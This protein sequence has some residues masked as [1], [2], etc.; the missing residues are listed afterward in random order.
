MLRTFVLLGLILARTL[1]LS[2]DEIGGTQAQVTEPASMD[3]FGSIWLA[4]S[5]L[6]MPVDEIRRTL[7]RSHV[8]GFRYYPELDIWALQMSDARTAQ[9]RDELLAGGYFEWI[10][11]SPR[12]V[13][14]A[15][16]DDPYFASRQWNLTLVD[17]PGAWDI[18]TGTTDVIIAII[19]TGISHSHADL[20]S[21]LWTNDD[22][23]AGNGIDDDGNGYV[24]DRWGWNFYSDWFNTDDDHGHGTH[25]AG[26]AG[27]ATNNGTGV[28]GMSWGARLMAVKFLNSAGV[29]DFLPMLLGMKYAVDNGARVLNLSVTVDGTL[30]GQQA[31]LLDERMAYARAKRVLVVGASGNQG[32]G[33]VSYPAAHP[34]ILSVGATTS[35]DTLWYSSNYGADLDLVAPGASIYSTYRI[36][37]GPTYGYL[38]GTSMAT[39]HV[40]GAAS[41]VWSINPDYSPEEVAQI[42][43]VTTDD[44]NRSAYPGPDQWMGWGRLNV[45]RAVKAA[46]THQ[47][48]RLAASAPAY[49]V[50]GQPLIITAT[51][52]TELG[53]PVPDGMAVAFACD[54]GTVMPAATTTLS[55]QAVAEFVGGTAPG[56]AT[57]FV[58]TGLV[59]ETL[60]VPIE[61]G[62]PLNVEISLDPS[63]IIAGGDPV[64]VTLH[65]TD[66]ALNPVADGTGL[67]F[68]VTQGSVSPTRAVTFSGQG[69]TSYIPSTV[70]GSVV[71][72]ARV[73]ETLTVTR[74]LTVLPAAPGQMALGT[75]LDWLRAGDV[76]LPI[77]ATIADGFGNAVRDG[78]WL[79]FDTTA[80]AILPAGGLTHGGIVTGTL[81]GNLP[82]GQVCITGSVDGLSE[83][84]CLAVLRSAVWLPC[85]SARS[86]GD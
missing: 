28:A 53:A 42:L 48:L 25:V 71:L 75:A 2:T 82:Q 1:A 8:S 61:P 41:L 21:K 52:S 27:A 50:L 16:P 64:T 6:A 17:A 63:E 44:V 5:D 22:E 85:L 43:R 34:D 12:V 23:I 83:T 51:V 18:T 80:G 14:A 77:T 79:T 78:V 36:W 40:A 20:A 24:D 81:S 54:V 35:S 10:V 3:T 70:A 72:G 13:A 49:R 47:V 73:D 74:T 30:T 62:P 57:L 32:R 66:G 59:T 4:R 19:D 76:T 29:G 15:T 39:P 11:P 67:K 58:V 84:R 9:V 31:T 37:S 26:I 45:H 60:S 68:E 65:I 7:G 86:I 38:S 33:T 46:A 55:G 69:S 56:S